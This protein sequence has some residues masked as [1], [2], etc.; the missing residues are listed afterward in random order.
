[1]I[2]PRLD[3]AEPLSLELADFAHADPH[4]RRAALERR[5]SASRSCC[6]ME[7]AEESLRR[8]GKPISLAVPAARAAA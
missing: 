4:R 1:M 5:S 7:A 3:A 6:A 8:N 2:V